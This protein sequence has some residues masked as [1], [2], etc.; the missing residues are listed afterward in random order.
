M[1]REISVKIFI[2][3]IGI[4]FLSRLLYIQV[5]DDS[6]VVNADNNALRHIVQYPPRGAIY[7]RNGEFLAQS[8]EAYDLLVTPREVVAFD[9]LEFCSIFNIEKEALIK[10]LDRAKKISRHK[11]TVIFKQFSKEVKLRFDEYHFKGFYTQ[12]RTIR[13][14]PYKTAGNLLGYVGEVSQAYIQNNPYYKSGDYAGMSGVEK[15]YEEVLRGEKGV[16]IE[17]VNVHGVSKGKYQDG[18][19]DTLPKPGVSIVSSIDLKL[20]LLGEELMADKIGSIVAIEPE[21]GEILAMVSAPTYNPDALI[22]R[23]RTKNYLELL[24]NPRRPLFNRAVMSRYPPGSTFKLATG[25]IGLQE[26]ILTVDTQYPCVGGYPIGRGVGCHAHK[27]PIDF[28]YS[29]QT[30]CNAYYC[31]VYRNIIDNKKYA[32]HKEGLDSW[33]THLLSM[34]FGRKLNS[35]FNGELQGLIPDSEFYDRMYKGGRWSSLTNISNSIGQGEVGVTILQLAN[36]IATIANRGHYIVPHIIKEIQDSTFSINELYRTKQY[37]DID[38]KYYEPVAEAM[39]RAVN[40]EGTG[41]R[42]QV[43]GLDICGKTGTAQNGSGRDHSTFAAFAPKD[44]PKIAISVYVEHGGFGATV[45]M[46]IASLMIE[47]YLTDSISRQDLKEYIKAMK[48]NYPQYD[49]K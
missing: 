40:V 2:F 12:Y 48:I 19:L 10:E 20:Q 13:Y 49:K 3:L 11:S 36:F 28:T 21:T 46:P 1:E 32:S 25:L 39:Y 31:Y 42:A 34:G 16:K 47:Q 33:R 23:D 27:S 14:Y 24:R 43:K 22:G 29:I 45:A 44:N 30:S 37:T 17:L 26:D 38:P 9:T 15:S 6:Y 41:V 35:D 8:S 4:I 5:I 18:L 7:D